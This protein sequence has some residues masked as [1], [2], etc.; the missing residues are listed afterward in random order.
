M[1]Y[2]GKRVHFV[3]AAFLDVTGYRSAEALELLGG[4][5]QLIAGEHASEGSG[6]VAIRISGNG[7]KPFN[8]I[9]RTV[10]WDGTNA[11][12]LTIREDEG[13]PTSVVRAFPAPETSDRAMQALRQE[14]SEL[15]SILDTAT[16]GIVILD[17]DGNIRSMSH[18]AEAL[19]GFDPKEIAGKP[20][21]LLL[22][23]ESQRSASDY[24]SGMSRG[25]MASVLNDGREVIG[26]E[27]HGRFIP[28]FMTIG[29]L[30]DSDGFC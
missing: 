25:G 27:A 6:R 7:I 20:F 24:I 23:T 22:A 26:R 5:D 10:P 18:S 4:I 28:L 1:I 30:E 21:S 29:R 15:S 8:T 14:A 12:M 17:A 9:I 2:S 16:D 3:N 19:F 13:A 11:M